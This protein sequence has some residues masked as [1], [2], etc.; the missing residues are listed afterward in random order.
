MEDKWALS[1]T[2]DKSVKLYI[3]KIK[4]DQKKKGRDLLDFEK[5]IPNYRD[6]MSKAVNFES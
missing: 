5:D 3:G 4:L 1:L 6:F 2:T